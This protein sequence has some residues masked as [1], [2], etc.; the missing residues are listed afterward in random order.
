MNLK[1]IGEFGFIRRISRG[2]VTRPDAVLRAIGDDAAAFTIN[3]DEIILVTTDL[4][5]ERIHFL[6]T[7][8]SGFDLGYKSLA[9]NLSDIAAMGGTACEAFISIA[10][11]GDCPIAYLDDFYAGMKHLAA[12]FEVNLLGGDTTSSKDDLIINV[13]VV[14]SVPEEEMLTRDAARVGDRICCTG[15]LGD[16]RAGLHLILNGIEAD[17]DELQELLT[18][19]IRPLPCLREGRFLA[20]QGSVHSAID[21][22]D[23]L[24]SDI[25]HIVE[26]SD[27][28][29]RL[30]ADAIPV[31]SNLMKFCER[32]TFDPIPYALA[33]GED[34]ML[35][36]TIR[37]DAVEKIAEAFR[38][39]FGK[40]LFIIGEITDSKKIELLNPDGSIT[41]CTPS[42]WNHFKEEC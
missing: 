30:Y 4:L 13:A 2:C 33:G 37:S 35:L 23:G 25:A 36:C 9:V 10:I 14:G 28:G 6:R 24:S 39:E 42:G 19:H 22:S 41:E 34:Y 3:P 17:S 7:A 16:S 31:S 38:G 12:D 1:D 20:Q 18:A 15:H 11:P 8:T 5:V 21:I 26:E 40:P 27:V 32:F 29:A